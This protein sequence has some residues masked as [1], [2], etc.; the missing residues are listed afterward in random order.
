MAIRKIVTYGDDVLTKKCRP[1]EKFD[2]RLNDLVN[3]LHMALGAGK[4]DYKELEQLL[5]TS[6]MEPSI[7]VEVSKV[8][9]QETSL[10]YL[11][12]EGLL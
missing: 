8:E 7:L 12:R 3:D 11:K 2:D 10:L 5:E 6:G 4:I 9:D 1:V